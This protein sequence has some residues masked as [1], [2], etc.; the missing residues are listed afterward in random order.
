MV[1]RASSMTCAHL[2]G[3]GRPE[4]MTTFRRGTGGSWPQPQHLRPGEA[5]HVDVQHQVVLFAAPQALRSAGHLIAADAVDLGT[6]RK[7]HAPGDYR[8]RSARETSE[9]DERGA[10]IGAGPGTVAARPAGISSQR[11]T[12]RGVGNRSPG[13]TA[14]IRASTASSS[15][16]RSGQ[17]ARADGGAWVR[18]RATDS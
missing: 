4:N 18:R 2:V 6:W 8:R 11:M 16:G 15:G 7:T 10:S 13:W 14:I 17:R 1:V 5:R 9:P 3:C 12:A